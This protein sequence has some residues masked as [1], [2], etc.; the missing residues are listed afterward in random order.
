MAIWD[1]AFK[2][3][4]TLVPALKFGD[5]LDRQAKNAEIGLAAAKIFKTSSNHAQK[6]KDVIEAT[7]AIGTTAKH[8]DDVKDIITKAKATV[9]AVAEKSSRH[10][11]KG[12]IKQLI[13][14][15]NKAPATWQ[16]ARDAETIEWTKR[17]YGNGDPKDTESL[18]QKVKKMLEIPEVL[19]Q[20]EIWNMYLFEMV[21]AHCKPE[22]YWEQLVFW[23]N[24]GY[25]IDDEKTLKGINGNQ[26]DFIIDNFGPGSKRGKH[27]K[28]PIINKIDT[29]LSLWPVPTRQYRPGESSGR[30]GI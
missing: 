6:V 27:F 25:R 19:D 14:D 12:P 9:P 2:T 18:Q 22:V 24:Y 16:K 20:D 1:L 28:R 7:R 15:L 11:S 5:F 4:S 3:I 13:D 8:A 29:F 23:S 30:K 26:K 10:V 17:L 21:L